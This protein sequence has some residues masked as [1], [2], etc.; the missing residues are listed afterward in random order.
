[1][2]APYSHGMTAPV[3]TAPASTA[4]TGPL[5]FE[6][7]LTP[8]RSLP[9]S[10]FLAILIGVAAVGFAAGIFSI[11]LGAWPVTGFCGLE[12]F[13][14]WLMFR[15]NYRSAG[16][17][18]WISLRLDRLEVGREGGGRETGRGTVQTYWGQV[19]LETADG[20]GR[21]WLR[22]HGRS[23]VIGTFLAPA[24]RLRLKE[25]LERALAT[26]RERRFDQEPRPPAGS[27]S[28]KR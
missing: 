16:R 12:F 28:R 19:V 27:G 17:S 26:L 11:R 2:A 1:P 3:D 18:E 23:L 13:L 25:N 22:S 7:R 4:Q 14:F 8:Y 10:A 9:R 5:L 21:L 20:R 15:L 6:V 24:E